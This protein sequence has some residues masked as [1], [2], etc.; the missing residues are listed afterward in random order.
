M[1]S[2]K[3]HIELASQGRYRQGQVIMIGDAPGDMKAAKGNDARF[4]PINPGAEENSWQRFFSEG[5]ARFRNGQF[6]ESY[7]GELIAEFERLLPST[8]PWVGIQ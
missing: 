2:K 1:G 8:P 3:E 6:T 5:A 7:E 4:F